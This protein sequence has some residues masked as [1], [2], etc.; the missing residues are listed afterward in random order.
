MGRGGWSVPYPIRGDRF[1]SIPRPMRASPLVFRAQ[2]WPGQGC[3]RSVHLLSATGPP[4]RAGN[5]PQHPPVPYRRGEQ[6]ADDDEQKERDD[7]LVSRAFA[8]CEP[9][10]KSVSACP[11]T[12]PAPRTL[13]TKAPRF[14]V[15]FLSRAD[16]VVQVGHCGACER[17]RT[18][19][20][21]RSSKLRMEMTEMTSK[22][23]APSRP[24]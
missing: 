7:P 11:R 15:A 19:S 8:F 6:Q 22:N 13:L 24:L 5:P 2:Q 18:G 21:N 10:G 4:I 14:D 20:A 1:P 23:P 3:P 16:V 17:A 9:G 12:T